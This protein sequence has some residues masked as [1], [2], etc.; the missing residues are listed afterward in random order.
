MENNKKYAVFSNGFVLT[1]FNVDEVSAKL[2][3]R[4]NASVSKIKKRLLNGKAAK[5]KSFSDYEEA[6]KLATKLTMLGL[7]CYVLSPDD[8][9]QD[10]DDLTHEHV[11]FSEASTFY[12]VSESDIEVK[13]R[14]DKMSKASIQSRVKNSE[15]IQ[16]K[17]YSLFSINNV[18][19]LICLVFM[20]LVASVIFV[21]K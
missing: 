10:Q 8:E 15:G 7:N 19:W 3:E 1:G 2:A 6:N 4:Y 18:K 20:L 13:R 21:N 11:S 16:T 12:T 5:V 14:S 17:L 9:L